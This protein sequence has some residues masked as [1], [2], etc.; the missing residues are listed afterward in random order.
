MSAA[1]AAVARWNPDA[2]DDPAYKWKAFTAVGLA[3]VTMVMSF[4]IIFLALDSI[5]TDFNVTLRQVSLVVIAQSLTVSALML[6]LGKVADMIGRKRFHLI[7]MLLFAVGAIAC[8]LSQ[9]LWMLVAF[10]VVMALG[11]TMGQA[12]STAIVTSVFPARER[13]KAMGSQT[14]A[15]ALGGAM[16]PIVAGITLQFLPWQALFVLM[17]VPTVIALAWG[18]RVLDDRKIGSWSGEE[19]PPYDWVGATLSAV[20]TGIIILTI[21]NPLALDLNDPLIIA[22]AATGT[23]VMCAFVWWQLRIDNPMLDLR[24]FANRVFGFSVLTRFLAFTRSS[25][26]LFLLPV[27]LVSFRGV[28]EGAAGAIMFLGALGMGIGAQAGGRL[29]DRFGTRPFLFIGFSALIVTGIALSQLDD[30]TS[31]LLIAAVVLVNGLAM[32]L[33]G[34]PN[35]SA[36]MG[37]VDRTR[38]G[39]VSAVINLSRNLGN[40]TGQ[41]IAT[42][43]I[44]GIMVANGFDIPLGELDENPGA[45]EAYLDGWRWAYYAAI[46]VVALALVSSVFTNPKGAAD[47]NHEP[48]GDVETGSHGESSPRS[49]SP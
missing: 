14:T 3:L 23:A 5:A 20:A 24:M 13:G 18:L 27:F 41:A 39:V 16:G 31:L 28:S 40:V 30:Q 15:V 25:A 10:R 19:R 6:P 43:I 38:Y 32:G 45:G 8:S 4:S 9:N 48:S 26:T 29:S 12:V 22:G 35:A 21:M 17:A 37:A 11:S 36:T 44:T 34:A 42:A 49:T 2:P 1:N 33:W 47:V 46:A 7:G